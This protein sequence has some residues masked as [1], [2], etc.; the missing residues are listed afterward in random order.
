LGFALA[1]FRDLRRGTLM[2]AEVT[3]HL[4]IMTEGTVKYDA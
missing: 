4:S 3:G 1:R 2:Q